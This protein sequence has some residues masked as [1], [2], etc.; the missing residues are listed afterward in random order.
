MYDSSTPLALKRWCE[1]YL[2]SVVKNRKYLRCDNLGC[3]FLSEFVSDDFD[4]SN[5][6]HNSF[7]NFLQ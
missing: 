4:P 2:A 1:P 6:R 7:L 5:Y 3:L